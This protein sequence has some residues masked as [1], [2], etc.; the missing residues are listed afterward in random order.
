MK[1]FFHILKN[2]YNKDINS[3]DELFAEKEAN[4]DLPEDVSAYFKYKQETG[5]GIEDFYNLQKDFDA[6][7]DNAVLANYYSSTKKV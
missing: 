5:R 7:D 4:V 1:T 2:R 3:V 6:M